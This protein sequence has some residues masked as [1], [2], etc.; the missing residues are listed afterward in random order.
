[1]LML[2][3]VLN[4]ERRTIHLTEIRE[5]RKGRDADGGSLGAE[6]GKGP[7]VRFF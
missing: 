4:V 7:N 5:G 6:S 1:M 3:E 2:M